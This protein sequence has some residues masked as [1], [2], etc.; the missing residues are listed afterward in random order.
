MKQKNKNACT[1]LLC[2][3]VKATIDGNQLYTNDQHTFLISEFM[4]FLDC[5]RI[6]LVTMLQNRTYRKPDGHL[7]SAVIPI[8]MLLSLTLVPAAQSTLSGK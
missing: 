3:N 6:D 2:C 1:K 5:F 8:T 4:S 7:T